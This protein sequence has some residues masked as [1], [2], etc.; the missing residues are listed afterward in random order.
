MSGGDRRTIALRTTKIIAEVEQGVGWLT[1]NNPE[2]RNAV[3]LEMWQG[4]GD[5]A[6]A[7]ED[8]LTLAHQE[9]NLHE[10]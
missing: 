9:G 5:A 6:Q 10:V 2:R 7:F 3:S 4:L 1:L 8:P